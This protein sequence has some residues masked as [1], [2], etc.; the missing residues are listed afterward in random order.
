MVEV[1]V[2]DKN[3][4]KKIID[5]RV[6]REFQNAF[7]DVISGESPVFD[8]LYKEKYKTFDSSKPLRIYSGGTKENGFDDDFHFEY[9]G[10][11]VIVIGEVFPVED[12]KAILRGTT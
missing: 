10:G 5:R 9:P 2:I 6:Y 8:T 1:T 4:D 7:S 3:K 11:I 12:M